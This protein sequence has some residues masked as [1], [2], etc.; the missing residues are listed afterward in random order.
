MARK[1]KRKSTAAPRATTDRD[2]AV[3]ALLALLAE[4]PF[5]QISLAD[6]AGRARLSLTQLRGEFGSTL[7]MLAAHIKQID[8]AVLAGGD[9]D[10]A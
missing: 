8:R 10:M 9:A 6:I 3:E 2:K 4:Q 5:E 1:S 7:A